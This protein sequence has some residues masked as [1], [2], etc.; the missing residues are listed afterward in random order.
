[1]RLQS[2]CVPLILVCCGRIQLYPTIRTLASACREAGITTSSELES[3]WRLKAVKLFLVYLFE[4][5]MMWEESGE[6]RS[7]ITSNARHCFV[8]RRLGQTYE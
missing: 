5:I 7:L 6:Q 8:A 4:G 2:A 3:F 1:M